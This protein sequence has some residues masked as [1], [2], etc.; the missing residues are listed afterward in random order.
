MYCH[1]LNNKKVP[2]NVEITIQ[3]LSV[4][5]SRKSLITNDLF[6]YILLIYFLFNYY[7]FFL[8]LHLHLF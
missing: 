2:N 5:N 7:Y 8:L 1:F 6:F 3:M 4:N